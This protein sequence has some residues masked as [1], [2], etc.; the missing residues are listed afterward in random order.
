[1]DHQSDQAGS[2][3]GAEAGSI[4]DMNDADRAELD[5]LRAVLHDA[6][7]LSNGNLPG[8]SDIDRIYAGVLEAGIDPEAPEPAMQVL[9]SVS[10]GM[11]DLIVR[12]HGYDWVAVEA[13]GEVL[14]AVAREQEEATA[15]IIP[16]EWISFHIDEGAEGTLEDL[17][18]GAL[19]A[20]HGEE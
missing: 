5:R 20:M 2:D 12:D 9:E 19:A 11:G 16:L 3:A 10:I 8:W 1:M 6:A 13:D 4:R 14:P 18:S 15:V 17:I 7:G